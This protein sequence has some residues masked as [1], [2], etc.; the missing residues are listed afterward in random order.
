MKRYRFK[1]IVSICSVL[2]ILGITNLGT[3]VFAAAPLPENPQKGS[4]GVQGTISSP[5]P[6]Q[7]ASISVPRPGQAFTAI[8]IDVSGI[9]P[10]GLLVKLFKNNVFSGS[11]QCDTGSFSIKTDL[12]TGANELVARVYD[13]LDQSGPDSNSVTV[14]F[15]DSRQGAGSRVTL[16][17]DYAKRGASPGQVLTWPI[18]LSG[19]EGPYAL[20]VD[21]GDGKAPDLKSVQFPGSFNI[22]HTY[23]SPGVYNVIVKVTDK[24]GFSAFLQVVGIANGALS[25][26]STTGPASK[27]KD[28]AANQPVKTK[29]LWQPVAFM[30]PFIFITFWLG[31]RY[32][33]KTLKR[34]IERGDRPF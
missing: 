32:E 10:K 17:S 18:I 33:L 16:T 8:P 24:N 9:C 20:S 2:L 26:D 4:V 11:Q 14:S 30:I 25:Q 19:G 29:I 13:A 27:N 1:S 21:W 7:G 31:K 28:N 34:K 12:F 22:E 23:D 15:N 5:P 6:T 3:S